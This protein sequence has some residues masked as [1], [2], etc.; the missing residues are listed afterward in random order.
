[1]LYPLGGV[2]ASNVVQ[3]LEF[4]VSLQVAVGLLYNAF[5]I[6]C[7]ESAVSLLLSLK[8]ILA[9]IVPINFIFANAAHPANIFGKA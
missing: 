1:M 5:T 8:S 6:D 7:S 9:F 4:N 3:D 2:V